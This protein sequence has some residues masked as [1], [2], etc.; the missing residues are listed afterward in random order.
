MK[1]SFRSA[2]VV[3]AAIMTAAC[4]RQ[5]ADGPTSGGGSAPPG[6]R[7]IEERGRAAFSACAVCHSV[8]NPDEP[9]YASLVGPSLFGVF[10]APSAHVASYDYSQAMREANLTWDEATLDRFLARPQE[11]IP[12]TRMAYV[13]EADPNKR[14]A[15]IAYLKTLKQN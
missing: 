6:A 1:I 2:I 5:G 10:G 12:R 4:G 9:G 14:A 11:V 15:I 13:G 7:T 3:A 8:K